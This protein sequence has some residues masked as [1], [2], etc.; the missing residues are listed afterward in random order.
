MPATV[1]WVV[2]WVYDVFD[3]ARP[4][5]KFGAP[6]RSTDMSTGVFQRILVADD[7]SPDGELAASVAVN[8]GAKFKAVVIL[9][10]VVEPPNVQAEGEGLPIDDPSVCRRMMEERFEKFLKL[11]KSLGVEMIVEIVE[12]NPAQQIRKR[13]EVDQAD[14]TLSDG[15]MSP[16]SAD[17]LRVR[18]RRRCYGIR[19]ARC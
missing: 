16:E 12:G 9:L 19:S 18:L 3:D 11:G 10:G 4:G 17:G 15:A 2:L 8:M 7:C 6:E 5:L 13:A 14:L 1:P